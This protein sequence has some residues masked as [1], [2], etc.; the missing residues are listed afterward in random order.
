MTENPDIS[1][2]TISIKGDEKELEQVTKQL[3]KQI[4]VIK[5]SEI[6][7]DYVE[8]R[9]ALIKVNTSDSE[10]RSEIMQIADVFRAN[11]VDVSKKNVT[12]EVT[13]D[14]DKIEAIIEMLKEHGIKEI[15]KT[16]TVALNRGKKSMEV[17]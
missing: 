6:S 7:K 10:D 2:M 4:E 17:D 15:A 16:G 1:R 8:R 12:I 3:N 13:G 11:V 14:R 5:V 9:L